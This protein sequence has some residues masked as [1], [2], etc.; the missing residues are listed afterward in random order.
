VNSSAGP[1]LP[2]PNKFRQSLCTDFSPTKEMHVIRHDDISANGPTMSFMSR[3]PFFHEY[4]SYFIASEN[5][6]SIIDARGD[7]I[8]R[9]IDPNGLKPSQMFMHPGGCSRGR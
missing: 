4:L 7:E 6:F 9:E 1:T 5:R 2:I 3:Q 8:N